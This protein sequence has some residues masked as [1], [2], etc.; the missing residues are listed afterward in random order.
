M[1][2]ERGWKEA[3]L[4]RVDKVRSQQEILPAKEKYQV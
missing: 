1:H 4:I 3:A 2:G